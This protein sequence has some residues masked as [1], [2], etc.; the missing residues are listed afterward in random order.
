MDDQDLP[1]PRET[2][3]SEPFWVVPEDYVT[4]DIDN[5]LL[6]S[7]KGVTPFE[8]PGLDDELTLGRDNPQV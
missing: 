1:V 3:D 4:D 7:L 5:G 6:I 8:L 2:A